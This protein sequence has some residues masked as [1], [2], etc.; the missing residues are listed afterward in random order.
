MFRRLSLDRAGCGFS[1]VK[2]DARQCRCCEPRQR[3]IKQ[4][5][6]AHLKPLGNP[7]YG[8]QPRGIVSQ[9]QVTPTN[10]PEGEFGFS[11]WGEATRQQSWQPLPIP[12]LAQKQG[13]RAFY[14]AVYHLAHLMSGY[15]DIGF[16]PLTKSTVTL[17]LAGW[18]ARI[19]V[20]D[21]AIPSKGSVFQDSPFPAWRPTPA[22]VHG[23][24][25]TDFWWRGRS[26]SNTPKVAHPGAG[27]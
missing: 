25:T 10:G 7:G 14:A 1:V 22:V 17:A 6:S 4:N 15:R 3:Y 11:G 24:C 26:F 20:M 9:Q 12:R 5:L 21:Y 2:Q 19:F 18:S 8:G 27:P 13:L 23:Q 16:C